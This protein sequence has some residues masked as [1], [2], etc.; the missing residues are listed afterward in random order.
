M[1]FVQGSCYIVE[2]IAK[3]FSQHD[4]FNFAST[5]EV[6]YFS[7]EVLVEKCL[8]DQERC[9]SGLASMVVV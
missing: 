1:R 9:L 2:N 5:H 6:S 3:L 7:G 8:S 4:F